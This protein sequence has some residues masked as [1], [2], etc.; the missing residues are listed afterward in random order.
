MHVHT[1]IFECPPG[2][3]NPKTRHMF[4]RNKMSVKSEQYLYHFYT[5]ERKEWWSYGH[6]NISESVNII[7]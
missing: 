2:G 5:W 3:L 4:N 7:S 6:I 1:N